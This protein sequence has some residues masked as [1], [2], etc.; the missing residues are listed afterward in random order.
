MA[1][2]FDPL[3]LDDEEAAWMNQKNLAAARRQ[4]S[5][6][7]APDLEP[8]KLTMAQHD[9]LR[10]LQME[11]DRARIR[12]EAVNPANLTGKSRDPFDIDMTVSLPAED[13]GQGSVI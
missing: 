3:E 9:E 1:Q 12:A 10:K 4:V 6:A 2:N 8:P 13:P 5:H 11:K 7:T